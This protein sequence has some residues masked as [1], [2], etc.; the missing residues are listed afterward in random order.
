[1]D[2][3]A[4]NLID[5][6]VVSSTGKTFVQKYEAEYNRWQPTIK[7]YRKVEKLSES[8]IAI[9]LRKEKPDCN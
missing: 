7:Y 8:K 4:Q 3:K 1:M 2:S 6:G 5:Y 9:K